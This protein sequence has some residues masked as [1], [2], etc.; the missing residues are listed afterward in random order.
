MKKILIG[1]QILILVLILTKVASVVGPVKKS[2]ILPAVSLITSQ[3]LAQQAVVATPPSGA[4]SAVAPAASGQPVKETL[5]DSLS[6]ERDLAAALLAKKNELDNR[7]NNLRTEEQRLQSLRKEITDKSALLMSQ[8]EKLT[9][10]LEASQT[11]D[12]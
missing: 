2:D 7:E 9:A 12:V 6:K 10:V 1:V 5:D 4:T 8:E 11:S 3:A